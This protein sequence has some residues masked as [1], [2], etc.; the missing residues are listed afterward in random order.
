[1][2]FFLFFYFFGFVILSDIISN[3]FERVL[4]LFHSGWCI[5][6]YRELFSPI[7]VTKRKNVYEMC[8]MRVRIACPVYAMSFMRYSA[9]LRPVR[10]YSCFAVSI[11]HFKRCFNPHTRRN[12]L[13][14][15][16]RCGYHYK[17]YRGIYYICCLYDRNRSQF[18]KR[19]GIR[20]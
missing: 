20:Y 12:H 2:I 19:T 16:G 15:C 7:I 4:L 6:L 11:Q 3:N 1:M 13:C 8:Q 14:D 5:V 9:D 10:E 17:H 18:H